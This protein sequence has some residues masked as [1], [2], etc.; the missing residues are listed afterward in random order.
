M[1]TTSIIEGLK[2]NPRTIASL[3]F[4]EPWADRAVIDE[5]RRILD[6]WQAPPLE[7]P[8]V[9]AWV[10]QVLGYFA[11]CYRGG[12]DEPQCWNAD[13]LNIDRTRDAIEHQDEHAGVRLI[14]RYY[15]TFTARRE[16]FAGAKWGS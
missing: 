1:H 5:A 12:G 11:S 10:S 3:E 6:A 7:S 16:H 8:E 13:K 15:P 4:D 2:H 9:Q 14:R